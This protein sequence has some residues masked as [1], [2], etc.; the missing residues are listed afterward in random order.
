MRERSYNWSSRVS[1]QFW[2]NKVSSQRP[3]RHTHATPPLPSLCRLIL[4]NGG[5]TADRNNRGTNEEWDGGAVNDS[6][7]L[8]FGRS[9]REEKGASGVGGGGR[10]DGLVVRVRV[11]VLATS[12]SIFSVQRAIA[13]HSRPVPSGGAFYDFGVAPSIPAILAHLY[14]HARSPTQ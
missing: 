2:V 7:L 9:T 14:A 13:F 12:I 4:G 6:D 8:A 10:I 11:R 1:R 3:F 5:C